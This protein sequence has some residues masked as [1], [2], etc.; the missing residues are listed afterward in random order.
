MNRECTR[1]KT[2][3]DLKYGF[4]LNSAADLG[5]ARGEQWH[6]GGSDRL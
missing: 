5:T 6:T 3:D 4:K 2:P 1:I